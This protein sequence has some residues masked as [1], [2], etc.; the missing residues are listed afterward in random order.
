MSHTTWLWH[1]YDNTL[2]FWTRPSDRGIMLAL[3]GKTMRK[4]YYAPN[5]QIDCIRREQEEIMAVQRTLHLNSGGVNQTMQANKPKMWFS[6]HIPAWQHLL[7]RSA[8]NARCADT[9]VLWVTNARTDT[10]NS[11]NRCTRLTVSWH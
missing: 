10:A 5:A 2:M 4:V 1:I 6:C 11:L 9:L 8:E 3:R 7:M